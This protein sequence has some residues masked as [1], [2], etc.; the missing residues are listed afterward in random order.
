MAIPNEGGVW[1]HLLTM[2]HL[3]D[4]SIITWKFNICDDIITAI[5]I[6]CIEITSKQLQQNVMTLISILIYVNN[7]IIF[8]II[9]LLEK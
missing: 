6:K 8:I 9:S 3:Y 5:M 1:C 7:I 4:N 2:F